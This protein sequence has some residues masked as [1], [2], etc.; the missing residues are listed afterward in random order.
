MNTVPLV[1][2]AKKPRWEADEIK[3]L[4]SLLDNHSPTMVVERMQTWQSRHGKY[5]RSR[6]VITAKAHDLGY[7]RSLLMDNL[8]AAC[9]AKALGVSEQAV[10]LW[11]RK[12][13]KFTQH[14]KNS[15]CAIKVADFTEW[16]KCN[17]GLLHA[18]DRDSL[19]YFVGPEILELV[20]K[21]NPRHRPIQ[22]IETGKI[23]P[24][25]AAAAQTIGVHEVSLGKA[26]RAGHRCRGYRWQ[27]VD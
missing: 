3:F 27:W 8:S 9:L 10:A 12:G 16:A 25:I 23:Y 15:L 1:H 11:R 19:E 22:C 18:C 5:I 17:P 4:E 7:D 20:P 14:Y 6:K 26:C 13:L 21:S 24:T 2:R